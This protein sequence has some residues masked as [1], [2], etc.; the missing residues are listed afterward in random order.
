MNVNNF[1]NSGTGDRLI[2][3]SK[4]PSEI[5][6][7]LEAEL[8]LLEAVI[9]NFD[10]VVEVGCMHGRFL[11]WIL[12]QNKYYVGVDIAAN[13]IAQGKEKAISLGLESSK[14]QFICQ[15]AKDLDRVIEHNPF[16]FIRKENILVFFPFNSLGNIEDLDGVV[17]CLK[18]IKTNFYI[19]SYKTDN[20]STEAREQYYTNCGYTNISQIN[21]NEGIRF[22][23]HEGLNTIAYHPN[24][25]VNRFTQI[26][27]NL[28]TYNLSEIGVAYIF[29]SD[30][31]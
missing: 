7:Y 16:D 1:Y 6:S 23:S 30:S 18:K 21:A 26:N 2:D 28:K 5:H 3:P 11:K 10:M 9:K 17:T 22:R 31:S 14:Y 13:Y 4:Y 29:D 8:N 24:F 27:I 25:L 15:D 12:M 20:F 19:S